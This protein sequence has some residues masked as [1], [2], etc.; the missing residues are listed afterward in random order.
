[1]EIFDFLSKFIYFIIP[2]V[3]FVFIYDY[4][5]NTT[6]CEQ[7]K[8]ILKIF[9]ASTSAFTLGNSLVYILNKF[10]KLNFEITK[11]TLIL[12]NGKISQASFITA[13]LLSILM[14]FI[15]VFIINNN[16][17]FKLANKYNITYRINNQDIWDNLFIENSWIIFR[18]YITNYTYFGKVEEASD[19]KEERELILCNVVIYDEYNEE[20]YRMEKIYLS[21]KPSEFSIEIDNYKEA[22]E[23][24]QQEEQQWDTL[25]G[26]I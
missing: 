23:N 25:T 26:I 14:S 3:I 4:L 11:T 5:T 18:D 19:K 17:I 2:G 22:K 1:M 16:L 13:I 21:R 8:L 24:E 6:K 9:V 15:C 10:L 12:T 7:L 20:L